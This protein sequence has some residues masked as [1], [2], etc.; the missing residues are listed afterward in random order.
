MCV[1]Y[2]YVYVIY[3]YMYICYVYIYIYYI[4]RGHVSLRRITIYELGVCI[5]NPIYTDTYTNIYTWEL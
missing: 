2:I 4:Y 1:I 5:C 3:I